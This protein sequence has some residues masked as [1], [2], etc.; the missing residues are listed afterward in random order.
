MRIRVIKRNSD[1]NVE[2]SVPVEKPGKSVA[3]VVKKWIAD[4]QQNG[5][6]EGLPTFERVF[7]TCLQPSKLA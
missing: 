7:G 6:A 3:G 1:T 2:K 5:E 4:V